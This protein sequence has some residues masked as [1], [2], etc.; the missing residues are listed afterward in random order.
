MR[1]G[2]EFKIYFQSP[3]G[4]E[5][6]QSDLSQ[7]RWRNLVNVVVGFCFMRIDANLSDK[8][9]DLITFA[10]FQGSEMSPGFFQ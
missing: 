6:F 1:K 8:G 9:W 4:F 5:S 2:G 7:A 3:E 10:Q